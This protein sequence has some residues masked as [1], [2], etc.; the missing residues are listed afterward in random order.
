[1]TTMTS[2][3][4]PL[5]DRTQ[6]TVAPVETARS[7][8]VRIRLWDLPTRLFHWS[9]VLA[10]SVGIVTGLVGG[11]WMPV[12]GRSGQAIIGLV[13]F[14]LVWGIIGAT[15]ARFASFVPTPAR[16]KAYLQG[17]WKGVGHNPLGALSVLLLLGLLAAQALSGL[18][19]NDDIAY[20]GP[21]ASLVSDAVS[22]RSTHL[23]HQVAVALY[24][25][26]ALHVLAILFHAVFK[27]DN[28][29]R[30]MVTGYKDVESGESTRS[31]GWTALVIALVA[32]TAAVYL[33]SG[34]I[35]LDAA[36]PQTQTQT[37]TVQKPVTPAW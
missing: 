13:A 34:T 4:P 16:V 24:V 35:Q 2:I 6:Q 27:K 7:P 14:R 29:V 15:H 9:L 18:F 21:L 5:G 20:T 32:A 8:L 36:S 23:H 30:P 33:V 3:S 37:Q 12:H 17:R 1:M 31:G 26:V 19:S 28:L 10:V 11:D 25:L 22:S